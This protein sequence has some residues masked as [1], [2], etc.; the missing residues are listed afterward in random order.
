MT[1]RTLPKGYYLATISSP[2][3]DVST[4]KDRA[5]F[6]SGVDNSVKRMVTGADGKNYRLAGIASGSAGFMHLEGT[7]GGKWLMD[8]DLSHLSPKDVGAVWEAASVKYA[9]GASGNVTAYVEGAKEEGVFRSK[10]LRALILNPN[11]SSLNNKDMEVLRFGASMDSSP[12][13]TK[14]A[15]SMLLGDGKFK[16]AK[17]DLAAAKESTRFLERGR[18]IGEAP[19]M[20]A[21]E[22]LRRRVVV[23]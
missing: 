6:Y 12:N 1:E 2:H 17:E 19:K 4:P 13:G 3:F 14:E 10:E 20:K 11:V 21:H 22:P 18:N 8:Q 23:G 16:A 5:I 9:K 15:F 7:P